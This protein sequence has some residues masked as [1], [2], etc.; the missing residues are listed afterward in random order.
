MNGTDTVILLQEF[1]SLISIQYMQMRDCA[2]CIMG[3]L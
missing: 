3:Q 1:V 2:F